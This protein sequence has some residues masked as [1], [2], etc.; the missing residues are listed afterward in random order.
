M[1]RSYE[2][3]AGDSRFARYARND[4]QKSKSKCFLHDFGKGIAPSG[5]TPTLWNPLFCLP[6][7]LDILAFPTFLSDPYLRCLT[8]SGYSVTR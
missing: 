7:D 4:N 3:R 8:G 1:F 6:D 5:L 2:Q